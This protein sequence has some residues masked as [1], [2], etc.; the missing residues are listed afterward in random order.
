[1]INEL[2]EDKK[3][4][5]KRD[6][7]I[8]TRDVKKTKK[9]R[10]RSKEIEK[11]VM[12]RKMSAAKESHDIDENEAVI[13]E[14]YAIKGAFSNFPN[15]TEKTVDVLKK[16][17]IKY[18]FPIQY[19]SFD[20]LYKRGDLMGRDLT[21]S[22]KTMAF[23]LPMLEY[24]RKHKCFGSK[25]IQGLILVPTRELALQVSKELNLLKHYDSEYNILTVYGGVSID[26]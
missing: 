7:K 17:G 23:A 13:N 8:K 2:I 26:D 1:M 6:D 5:E 14:E 19:E 18:L 4:T 24:F 3:R 20:F 25:K 21:G 15:I 22:G 11:H 10:S 9:D 12:T 16:R